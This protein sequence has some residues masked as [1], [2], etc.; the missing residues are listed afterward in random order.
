MPV[1]VS[2][3][4]P[5]TSV[6]I[7]YSC[8]LIRRTYRSTYSFEIKLFI[9][10]HW[11]STDDW[12]GFYFSLNVKGH[13]L[14]ILLFLCAG[15]S[16]CSPTERGWSGR[17]DKRPWYLRAHSRPGGHVHQGKLWKPLRGAH[18]AGQAQWWALC[19]DFNTATVF[20]GI[21][22][23]FIY[24]CHFMMCMHFCFCICDVYTHRALY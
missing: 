22:F 4:A 18:P 24:Y 15:W 1:I 9:L 16:V 2:R 17:S 20:W 19:S 13:A 8:L 14:L 23:L 12:W 3:V 11:E 10:G 21:D 5:G 7:K 6:S